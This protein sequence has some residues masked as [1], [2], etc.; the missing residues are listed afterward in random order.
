MYSLTVVAIEECLHWNNRFKMSIL[1]TF[2]KTQYEPGRWDL[3]D[4]H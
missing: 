2:K 1:S 4:D 3:C